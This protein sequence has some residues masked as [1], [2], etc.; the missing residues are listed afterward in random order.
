LVRE[1][2]PNFS[3][4]L[5]NYFGPGPTDIDASIEAHGKYVDSLRENGLEVTILPSLADHPDCCFVEDVAVIIDGAAVICNLGHPSRQGEVESVKESLSEHLETIVM[6][7]RAKL[8]GGDVVFYDDYFLI[9][10]STRTNAAGVEFIENICHE[11]GF[12]TFI[13][14]VPSTTLHLSTICSS[15]APGILVAAEG[16]LRPEQFDGITA[17]II[18]VPNEESYA[19]NTIG[20]ENGCVIVSEGYPRTA[21]LL[22]QHGFSVTTIDMEHIRCADGSLTCLRLFFR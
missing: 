22:A 5:S 10:R 18:W 1:I 14:D 2:S 17:E 16:H 3:K 8:D 20:F 21:Q 6:P 15:P 9:G 4:A 12:K 11:R 7:V 19:A 13:F